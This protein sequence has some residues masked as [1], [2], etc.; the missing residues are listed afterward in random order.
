VTVEILP[1]RDIPEV[2]AGDD[3]AGLVEPALRAAGLRDGDVLAVTQKI[4]SKAEGRV[5]PA[6]GI[7]WVAAESRR[8]LAR[9]D[10]IVIAETRH[11]FV[12]ANAGVDA[13]NVAEGFVS[14]LPEDPDGS[15]EELRASIADRLGRRIGVVI[16]DTF[17]R[18]W[19]RGVV[20]VAIGCSGLPALVD[21]RGSADD[22]G[23][24]LTATIVAL[25]DEIAAASGLAMPKAGRIPAAIVRGISMPVEP[26]SPDSTI[27]ASALVRPPDEDLFRES[28]LSSISS[29]RAIRSFEPDAVPRLAVEEAVRAACA[30][31]PHEATPW[32][33]I[34]L[35]SEPARRRLLRAMRS[36]STEGLDRAPLLVLPFVRLPGHREAEHAGTGAERDAFLLS[37]GAAVQG[38]LLALHAQGLA[39]CWLPSPPGRPEAMRKALS[40]DDEWTSTGIVAVGWP[41]NDAS[42]PPPPPDVAEHLR[43]G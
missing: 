32:L 36:A 30:A 10:E 25:A 1:L 29:R 14:L 22:R 31:P 17:G 4:I 11:G 3:L 23:R 13:S 34:A 15:A 7:D 16:T 12:C 20:N 2:H 33:F 39:S 6:R 28:P 5:V 43:F 21:L 26:G 40:L 18:A 8:V 38:L 35:D 27:G 19:R 42:P 24:E 37:S 9:R 41:A